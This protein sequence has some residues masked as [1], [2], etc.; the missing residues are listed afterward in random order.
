M[1]STKN[2]IK[3]PIEDKGPPAKLVHYKKYLN[4]DIRL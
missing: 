1:M 3:G 4:L 2:S